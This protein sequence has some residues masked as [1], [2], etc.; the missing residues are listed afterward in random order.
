MTSQ[1]SM[2]AL[3]QDYLSSRRKLGYVLEVEGAELLR[4]A[5]FADRIGHTGPLTTE[6]AIR[7]AKLPRTAKP[8]YWAR[9]LDVVRRFAKALALIV[10]GTEVPPEG[11]LGPSYRRPPPHIYSPAEVSSLL[12]AAR[13]LGPARGLRSHTYVTLFGLLA[14]TGLRISEALALERRDVDLSM[15]ILTIRHAK[16]GKSRQLPIHASTRD[17]LSAYARRRDRYHPGPRAPAF[18]L[19]EHATSQK[20]WRTLMTFTELRRGLGWLPGHTG[21]LPRIH[22]LR[23]TF[24]V[25]CLLRWQRDGVEIDQKV[26]SLSTYLGHAKVSDTYWYLSAVPELLDLVSARFEAFVDHDLEALP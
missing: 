19:T 16:F 10:P 21:R 4:F 20:Y 25:R 13:R 15:G 14:C 23:H 12:G 18:F 7:W 1:Y 8:L 5:R 26:L 2:V 17:A 3:A 6:L 22:D 9:R 24:A 11:L